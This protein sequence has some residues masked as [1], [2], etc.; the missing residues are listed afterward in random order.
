ML[1]FFPVPDPEFPHTMTRENIE[2]AQRMGILHNAVAMY[3]AANLQMFGEDSKGGSLE[4]LPA[5]DI[6]IDGRGKYWADRFNVPEH[7]VYFDR[8]SNPND[9]RPIRS[10]TVKQTNT[11]TGGFDDP[12]FN[13]YNPRCAQFYREMADLMMAIQ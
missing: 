2:N 3:I 12:T 13:I 1:R 7:Y 11:E 5:D 9:V 8:G 10:V 4:T 6:Y